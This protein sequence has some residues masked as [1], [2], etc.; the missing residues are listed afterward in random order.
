MLTPFLGGR[1]EGENEAGGDDILETL[2]LNR[3]SSVMLLEEEVGNGNWYGT[4]GDPVG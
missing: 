2:E 1:G 3:G 4:D